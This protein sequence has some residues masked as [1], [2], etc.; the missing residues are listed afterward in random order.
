MRGESRLGS[1]TDAIAKQRSGLPRGATDCT[2]SVHSV[3]ARALWPRKTAAHWASRAGV[4]E[5][6]AKYWLSGQHEVS[7]S[8]KLAIRRALDE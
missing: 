4:K 6:M 8:G 5:R 2:T 7:D 1:R 3:V